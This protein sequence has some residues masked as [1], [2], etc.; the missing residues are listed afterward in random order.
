MSDAYTYYITILKLRNIS[1]SKQYFAS[2]M[3]MQIGSRHPTSSHLSCQNQNA[4]CAAV[5][6]KFLALWLETMKTSGGFHNLDKV[7]FAKSEH[8]RK[9]YL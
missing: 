8:K 6:S 9:T 4:C 1:G 5:F 3:K 7:Y 2:E